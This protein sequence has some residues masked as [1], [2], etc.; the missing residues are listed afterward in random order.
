MPLSC[1]VT[2]IRESY[3]SLYPQC[4]GQSLVPTV[5]GIQAMFAQWLL[6]FF[7]FCDLRKH[8]LLQC[9]CGVGRRGAQTKSAPS[10]QWA[11]GPVLSCLY[12]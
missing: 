3:L 4:L 12:P 2:E 9:H 11:G 8:A 1:D 10:M 5:V 7:N 6:K